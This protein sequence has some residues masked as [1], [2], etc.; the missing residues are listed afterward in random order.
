MQTRCPQCV[1]TFRV[2]PQQLKVHQGEVR[3]GR[4]SAIFDAFESLVAEGAAAPPAA[5]SK[6][7]IAGSPQAAVAGPAPDPEPAVASAGSAKSPVPAPVQH[8]GADA[9]GK[10][11]Q[12][13]RRWPWVVLAAAAALALV[14]QAAYSFRS[15]LAASAAMLVPES[16]NWMERACAEWHCSVPL[17]RRVELVSIEAS[18]L[19]VDTGHVNLMLLTATLKNR[20]PFAQEYPVLALT[21]TDSRDQALAR[22]VLTPADY[23]ERKSDSRTGFAAGADLAIKVFI[24]TREIKATGYRLFLFYS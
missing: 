20:A 17:P 14:L 5:A 4:C 7:S 16:R 21:L 10:P 1:T 18:D 15:E 13:A 2:S 12:S 11:V 6:D 8:A 3:C 24:D 9:F 23:L 19:Q 22:R